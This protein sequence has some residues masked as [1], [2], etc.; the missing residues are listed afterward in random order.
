[1][2][3]QPVLATLRDATHIG[4][5]LAHRM[6]SHPLV[7][8]VEN[9][10]E[11]ALPAFVAAWDL[12]ISDRLHLA[13]ATS[14]Y[15]DD[16][17]AAVLA[18]EI[19]KKTTSE[20]A[21]AYFVHHPQIAERTLRA[22]AKTKFGLLAAELLASAKRT[23]E[24]HEEIP[25]AELPMVLS[26]PPWMREEKTRTT[27][28]VEVVAP[29]RAE[30]IV[31]ATKRR[32]AINAQLAFPQFPELGGDALASF[33]TNVKSGELGM[34]WLY[35]RSR[36]PKDTLLELIKTL[37]YH[38]K[39][40]IFFPFAAATFYGDVAVPALVDWAEANWGSVGKHLDGYATRD[41][42]ELDSHRFAAL[43]VSAIETGQSRALAW[44]YFDAHL[45]ATLLGV[46]PVALGRMSKRRRAAE[47]VLRKL[48]V[49]HAAR[50]REVAATYGERAAEE[51]DGILAFDGRWDCPSAP[52]K[53]PAEWRPKTFTRPRAKD[54]RA[55][56]L[57]AVEHI[58]HMLA[59]S[60][61]DAPYIGLVDV[62]EACDPRS[63]AEMAWD[64]ARAWERSNR[65]PT[66]R[67]MLESIAHLGDDE[68]I[69]RTTPAIKCSEVVGVL[70][71]AATDA[72][73]T[74][75]CTIAWR[76]KQQKARSWR[77][78]HWGT[79]ATVMSAFAELAR[80]RDLTVDQVADMLS[81]TI[82]LSEPRVKLDYGSRSIDVGFDER[83]DPFIES[84][85][86]KLRKLPKA[87][88]KDDPAKVARA[89]QIWDEL[90]EDVTS[91]ADLRLDSLERAMVSGREWTLDAF[92]KAW[93]D[94]PLMR[95]L[96]RGVVWRAGPK[97]FRIAEDGSFADEADA[98]FDAVGASISAAHPAEMRDDERDTWRRVF[99][100]YRIAQ[101]LEQ[102][103]RR[104]LSSASG[105]SLALAPDAP[106]T[107]RE[108]G[109]K[110]RACGFETSWRDRQ[111]IATRAC[112][113]STSLRVRLTQVI[114]DRNVVGF[115]LALEESAVDVDLSRIHPVEL[116]E[117]VHTFSLR[118]T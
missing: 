51:V 83:L 27:R 34:V 52:P 26:Q 87:G 93:M 42:M 41:M 96:S 30:T 90:L 49:R 13:R 74:E 3:V 116:S 4:A 91:I 80:R 104:V 58:G 28:V 64:A 6:G 79:R 63:L 72:A 23:V 85:R 10:G 55:L 50:V 88:K 35:E 22:K 43:L 94:H 54:G 12:P 101:P 62:R 33:V 31:V 56:P 115:T 66:T 2:I 1:M 36:L 44:K 65:R 113:R 86:G 69:R 38:G 59:F 60:D 20:I 46:I 68:V 8:A 15:L 102:L 109:E 14:A 118:P 75:L 108:I 95:H 18:R 105:L 103:A 45:D 61:D 37:G 81:P 32:E 92:R 70:G 19:D 78:R 99:F 112:S 89:Q 11:A 40:A 114:A 76:I 25:L 53:M 39:T 77:S 5:V 7:D 107:Q 67:W 57:E 97:T 71:R 117:I 82:A 16:R 21:R 17:A 29:A 24:A 111:Q 73:A 9:L 110:M 98:Q 47:S 106:F 100:D 48:A 84:A